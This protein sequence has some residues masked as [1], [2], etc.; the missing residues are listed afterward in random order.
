VHDRFLVVTWRF[1]DIH[2]SKV[3]VKYEKSTDQTDGTGIGVCL[4]PGRSMKEAMQHGLSWVEQYRENKGPEGPDTMFP[5]LFARWKSIYRTRL[6]VL[7]HLFFVIGNGYAW[8]DGGIICTSGYEEEVPQ[9][10]PLPPD[11]P[12]YGS[13]AYYQLG[14][15]RLERR[16]A[17]AFFDAEDAAKPVGPL[18]DDGKP[19]HFYPV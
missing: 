12:V 1:G 17:D 7:D 4:P 6:D 14:D 15:R 19:R 11:A 8:L 2:Q 5:K 10:E 3:F 16:I 13:E 18:P 9:Q